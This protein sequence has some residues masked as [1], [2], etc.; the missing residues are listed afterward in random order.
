MALKQL[1]VKDVEVRLVGLDQAD[2][3]SLTDI[4]KYRSPSDAFIVIPNA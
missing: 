3:I 2:Y 1:Q 4:A